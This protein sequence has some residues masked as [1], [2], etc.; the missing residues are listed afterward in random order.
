MIRETMNALMACVVT[1]ALCAIAYPAVVYVAGHVLFPRQ[2]EGSLIER[3]GKTV[4][5]ELIAQPFVSDKYISPRPSAAGSNGYAAD[6]ASGSNLATTNPALRDRIAADVAKQIVL[7]TGDGDLK[8]KLER[9]DRL[10]SDLKTRT[11]AAAM[12]QLESEVSAAKTAVEERAA[13][14][15]E[16]PEN[17]V[18]L[19]LVTASGS[20]LDPHISPEAALYQAGRVAAARGLPVRLIEETI[21]HRIERS[22]T[23]LGAPPRI[24]VLRLNLDLDDLD[25]RE[26]R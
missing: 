14:L 17:M 25:G 10:Q 2:S 18:P 24:N 22:G 21:R 4:G 5:S 6:A 9:L 16:V 1:F 20:G 26:T 19:D 13:A 11:D 7:K 8:A 15:G 3:E 23:I 12:A